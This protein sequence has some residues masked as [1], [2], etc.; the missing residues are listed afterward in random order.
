SN[1]LTQGNL[2]YTFHFYA[3]THDTNMLTDFVGQLPIFVTEWGATEASGAGGTNYARAQSFVDI[4]AANNIS[5]AAWGWADKLEAVS[6]LNL[7]SCDGNLTTASLTAAGNFVR[8]RIGSNN[9]SGCALPT[10][11]P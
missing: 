10:T 1:K 6:Q 3:A 8:A 9:W 4:M 11:T 7:N 5:W 2:L